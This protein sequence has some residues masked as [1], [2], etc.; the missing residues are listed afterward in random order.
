MAGMALDGHSQIDTAFEN[1]MAAVG[2]VVHREPWLLASAA[3][4]LHRR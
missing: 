4:G 1:R 2:D 3:T